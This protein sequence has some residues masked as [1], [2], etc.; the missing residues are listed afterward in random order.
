[1]SEKSG[2]AEDVNGMRVYSTVLKYDSEECDN[3][4]DELSARAKKRIKEVKRRARPELHESWTWTSMGFANNFTRFMTVNDCM[5]R[6]DVNEISKEQFIEFYEKPYNPV[7]IMG[8]QNNWSARQKWTLHRLRKKY[9]NQKFK[10]GE[11]NHGYS[12]KMKM[13]YFVDY[14]LTTQ[15]DSPL[16]IFDS[17]FGE[18]PRRCKLL[19][20]YDIPLYFRDDLFHLA[21]EN[22]RPPYR[23]FVMGPARSGTGIH[24][25]PLGTSAWNALVYGHK[26]W[27]LFPTNTPK[28]LL[29][30]TST[31]GGKQRDE[32]VT[33][34][35]V[36]YPRTQLPSWPQ[37]FKP[38]EILQ[39]P[40]ETVFVPGG[41][42]H[43]VLNLDTTIAVTQNF[44]SKTNFPVVWH[45]TLRGRPKLAKKWYKVLKMVEPELTVV[46]DSIDVDLDTGVASDSSSS[47]SSSSTSCDSDDNDSDSGQ[48]SLT[49]HKKR[50]AE[51]I[52]PRVVLFHLKIQGERLKNP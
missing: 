48:E 49:P 2:L 4:E 28:E 26:R 22:R 16:Y 25:D 47:C 30:V 9:R 33:W 43:V 21:G 36:I 3:L 37:E 15:D 10:C 42:W 17:G 5:E 29:K 14:L 39:K 18:D 34:F 19:E 23:W 32:A 13:K 44:C 46:A 6:I 50:E 1:M 40:G 8:V 45:K 31:E 38:V 11:D 52:K 20:D 12:V 41:W 7:V 51:R 35:S 27:C 24:I